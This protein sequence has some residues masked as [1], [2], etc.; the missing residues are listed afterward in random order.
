MSVANARESSIV[1]ERRGGSAA[2][3]ELDA[4]IDASGIE[5]MPNSIDQLWQ[6]DAHGSGSARA[7][8]RLNL[9]SVTVSRMRLLM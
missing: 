2:A 8:T 4:F 1:I 6:L 5:L 7:S 3:I 9:I